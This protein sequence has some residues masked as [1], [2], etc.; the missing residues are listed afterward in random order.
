MEEK[1]PLLS[2]LTPTKPK[3]GWRAFWSYDCLP[4]IPARYTLALVS[5]LGFVNVYALRVNLSVAVVQ[6]ANSTATLRN[7]SAEVRF[8]CTLLFSKLLFMLFCVLINIIVSSRFL[9]GR[10]NKSVI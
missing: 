4:F 6:M 3:K 9:I 7:S 8:D 5:C 2:E 10:Q 1:E